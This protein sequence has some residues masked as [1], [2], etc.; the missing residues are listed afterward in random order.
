[1]EVRIASK[2]YK[3]PPD[4]FFKH[5]R[6]EYGNQMAKLIVRRIENAKA[7]TDLSVLMHPGFPGR[8]HWLSG[9]RKFQ[10]SADLIH[11]KRLIFEPL[12]SPANFL[13]SEGHLDNS[14]IV[15]LV[16]KEISDTHN[17]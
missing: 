17:E 3:G 6:G 1:M 9:E 15:S 12:E 11:P 16:V 7:A 8:W 13:N 4:G 14:K 10:V 5:C 2:F